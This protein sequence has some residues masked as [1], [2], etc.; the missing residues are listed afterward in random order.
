[1]IHVIYRDSAG[2]IWTKTENIP[3]L[4]KLAVDDLYEAAYVVADGDEAIAIQ[5]KFGEFSQVLLKW[6]MTIPWNHTSHNHKQT[7]TGDI[8]RTILANLI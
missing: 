8:A 6:I 5:R 2:K 1:M 3:N 7:W 4:Y